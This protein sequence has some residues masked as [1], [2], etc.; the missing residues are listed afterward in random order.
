[1][2]IKKPMYIANNKKFDNRRIVPPT[3]KE[4][5]E[6]QQ[7]LEMQKNERFFKL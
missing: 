4:L 2:C 3:L 1:M 7:A 5:M 6:K